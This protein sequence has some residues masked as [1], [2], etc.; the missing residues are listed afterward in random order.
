MFCHDRLKCPF[1]RFRIRAVDSEFCVE[2]TEAMQQV[3]NEIRMKL[4]KCFRGADPVSIASLVRYLITMLPTDE[5]M[6]QVLGPRTG[7]ASD[8]M[9]RSAEALEEAAK[10]LHSVAGFIGTT[11]R[12]R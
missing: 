6:G 1:C 2:C 10:Q 3:Q 12:V 8:G 5:E 4:L 11:K 7:I 9:R